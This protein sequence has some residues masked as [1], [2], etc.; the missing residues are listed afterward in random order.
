M[1]KKSAKYRL[2]KRYIIIGV[3]ALLI[4]LRLML[5]WI[6]LH[7]CNKTLAHL[8]GYYGHVQDIDVALYRGAYV[9]KD[10]YLN[11]VDTK[12]K[13][14]T[15]FFKV[16]NIDLSV[17]W[18]AL[19][20][21]RLVGELEINKPKL[22]FT[23]D[24]TEIGEV[25]KDTNDFRK[26]LKNFMPLK[27]NRFEVN[28]GSVH[29]ADPTSTPKVDIS[30]Q[31]VH[32]RAENLSNA[33]HDK[34]ALPSPVTAQANVYGGSLALNMKMNILAP[35]TEL[36][37]NADVKNANLVQLNDFLKAYGNFD[38]SRG[39]LSLYTEFAA[40]DGKYV[41]YVKPIIKDL[42]VLG[43]Q[44]SSDSFLHKAWEALV[45]LTADILK[46]HKK[47]QIAS[48]VPIQGEFDKSET[49]ISEAVWELLKNAFIHAL[50][51]AVDNQIN[52]TSVNNVKPEHEGL[53]HKIF[54]GGK[55]DKHDNKSKKNKKKK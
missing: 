29:Y 31:Q 32:V 38:V 4:I 2:R 22:I 26:V 25:K 28:N 14:Q 8:D 16:D 47:D 17:Q 23:K 27:V 52:L 40:K 21:G 46:N 36:D 20:H 42:K 5:P 11:K 3:V 13:K 9:I 18:K 10:M 54:G 48:K 15:D 1:Q 7:Y 19:F 43:P 33:E 49:D 30:M 51:P 44:D 50:V 24:K 37:L 35:K 55:K 34:V 39:S 6:I 41:G 45:G 12:T 53:L